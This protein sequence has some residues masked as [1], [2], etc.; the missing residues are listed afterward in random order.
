MEGTKTLGKEFEE[1][2]IENGYREGATGAVVGN[3]PDMNI[4]YSPDKTKGDQIPGVAVDNIVAYLVEAKSTGYYEIIASIASEGAVSTQAGN[5]I[6][7]DVAD[8][9]D[10]HSDTNNLKQERERISGPLEELDSL[11]I[12][13]LG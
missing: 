4:L 5:R 7:E 10:Q 1:Y 8:Y 3:R 12:K 6:Y 13:F 9:I 2:L 11:R